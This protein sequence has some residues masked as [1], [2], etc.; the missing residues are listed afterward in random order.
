MALLLGRLLSARLPIQHCILQYAPDSDNR[1]T[2]AT[3]SFN[4]SVL[5]VAHH[6][7]M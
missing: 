3:N 2:S 4:P 6:E 1:Y 5:R 7:K